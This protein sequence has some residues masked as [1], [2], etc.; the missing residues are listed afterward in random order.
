MLWV[1]VSHRVGAQ[2]RDAKMEVYL[3]A[4]R[5]RLAQAPVVSAGDTGCP[6]LVPDCPSV[7]RSAPEDQG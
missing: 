6:S 5:R 1:E 7:G 3:E 4:A 2:A